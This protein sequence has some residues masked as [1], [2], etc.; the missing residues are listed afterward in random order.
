MVYSNY[1][2]ENILTAFGQIFPYFTHLIDTAISSQTLQNSPEPDLVT[3][4]TKLDRK[5]SHKLLLI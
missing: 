4:N 5:I 1:S 2:E 3:L